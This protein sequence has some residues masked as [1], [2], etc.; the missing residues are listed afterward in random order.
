MD[1]LREAEKVDGKYLNPVPTTVGGLKMA[2]RILPLLL[3]NREERV[4]RTSLGPF[5]TDAS[6]YANW[7]ASGLR[8]TWFGH[9]STL[10]EID[11]VRILIDPVWDQRASPLTWAGPKRFFAPTLPLNELPRL[12]AVLVSHDHYDHLGADTVRSLAKLQPHARW[13]TSLEVGP[14][15]SQ[16]G[17]AENRITELNW[18]GSTRIAARENGAVCEITSVSARHFSGRSATRR[19]NTLWASFVLRGSRHTVYYGADSGWWEGFAQ[20]GANYGPFDLT[21]LEIGA[22]N[23]LWHQIHLGPDNAARAYQDLGGRARAGLLMPVHWGLFS[24]AFHAWRQPIERL[25]ELAT[26]HG[27]PLWSSAPGLPTEVVRGREL[28]S[29]WWMPL[30]P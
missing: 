9:S 24:L 6:V 23:E 16:L 13:L 5:R 29:D 26:M 2:F 15:L 8:V 20:I 14:I 18:T 3:S 25:S 10:V 22:F 12:D 30:E 21:M 28:Q 11:G 19:F 27:L 7:P 1:L 4:P 17:V